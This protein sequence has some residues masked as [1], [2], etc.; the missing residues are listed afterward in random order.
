MKRVYFVFL[1]CVC[2]QL[3]H[4]KYA[5]SQTVDSFEDHFDSVQYPN[6]PNPDYTSSGLLTITFEGTLIVRDLNLTNTAEL[7]IDSQGV[8]LVRGNLITDNQVDVQAGGTLI[9]LGNFIHTGADNQGRFTSSD[10]SNVYILGDILDQN[11]DVFTFPATKYPV[12]QC[13]LDDGLTDYP[14]GCNYG[15]LSDLIDN[16]DYQ[17]ICGK[18]LTG[19]EI[20]NESGDCYTELFFGNSNL[21]VDVIGTYNWFYTEDADIIDSEGKPLNIS[22]WVSIDGEYTESCVYDGDVTTTTY[23]VRQARNAHGCF[24][25]SD[26]EEVEPSAGL[27]PN[28]LGMYPD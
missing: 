4:S 9:I 13:G 19:G 11:L 14:T 3:L 8:L 18:G 28:P 12:L 1:T 20:Y 17:S 5:Y 10:P 2:L 16:P 21:A 7:V 24:I 15:K 27:K 22:N 25:Y 23:F 26:I 6:A